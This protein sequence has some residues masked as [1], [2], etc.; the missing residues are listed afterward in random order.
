[1]G[2]FPRGRHAHPP[3]L[4]Q[5]SSQIRDEVQTL[6]YGG[7]VASTDATG[8]A[9]SESLLQW[10]E[11]RCVGEAELQAALAALERSVLRNITAQL[12]GGGGGGVSRE[13]GGG[14]GGIR[15]LP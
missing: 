11:R 13:V 15:G 10:L 2:D 3:P 6:V 5:I 12:E 4:L 9:P 1:M 7:P 14:R 8:D